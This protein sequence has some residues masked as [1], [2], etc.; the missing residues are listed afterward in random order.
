MRAMKM[1]LLAGAAIIGNGAVPPQPAMDVAAITAQRFGNDAPW[2]RDRI[3]FFESADPAIDAVYYYR[4]QVFRAHQRDLGAD[5]YITTEFADDVDWQR[6]PY[7]SLNDASGFHIGEGR[8]LNDRRFADDY[9]N[10]MYRSGGND[11][12]FTDHMADSVWGRFLVD[13]D[14]ADAIEHLPVMNHIYRLWDDKYDFDKGLYFVE[15]LL[16]ATE[17][18]VSSIDASGGKDGF[19]G[20]DAFRPSVNSYMFANARALAKM[21]TMAGNTAMAADYAARAD[22]LQ[23]R[24]LADLW[25][26]KL[27]HF[28]DRHQSR[29]NEH[30]NYWQ[31]IRNREL[32]GYLPW[33]FDLVPDNAHYAAAWAHLLDPASLAGKAGMRTVEASYEYYMQQYRYLGAAPE[34]QWNGPVWPYQTTQIL[35]GMANLLDHARATGPITRS[36]YMRLLRQYAALHYQ[37]SRLDIEEDYHPETGKPIVGL[38]RSHHY[39]HSGFNDLILTGLVG[40]RPRA[41]DMLEVNPLLPDAADSQALAWFRV[42][43]VPYHGH[44]IAVTWDDN[45]SHYKRGK[46]LSIEVDGKEVARRDRLGRVEIPVA[47]AATPAI[48]RPINRAVQ[49]VRGQFPIGSA[50]SNSDA[51]NI[52]DAIDGRTWFFPELPNG[53][54]SASSPAA[55]WYAIDLGNPV[56]LV[57]AELAFFA[58]GKGFAVPQSYRLQAWVDGDWRDIAT[59]RGSPVANGVTDARWPRLRTSKIRLL[60]TQPNGKATRLAEFKLFEE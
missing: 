32:V 35:H 36:A 44:K 53:W 21:A 54:S 4:W 43:D 15:P 2:Y 42:Q 41:D 46:G 5:G 52:H 33:M 19:R 29:K 48:A 10:F 51:E 13:G 14:R 38:D 22:A 6:H 23:K 50:S 26:E 34:C 30:V 18:T 7:A 12:H 25:S 37:G 59:P 24:V 47:R 31:P 49:L 40:I 60:F 45:G 55:Q 58:D 16:D 57:R 17:Y 20:G 56:A 28:I 11:R 1:L 27:A 39:F 8:W 3:P 9:I